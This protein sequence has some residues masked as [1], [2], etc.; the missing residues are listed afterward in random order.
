MTQTPLQEIL[1][2]YRSTVTYNDFITV[3]NIPLEAYD[4]V[5]NGTNA[6]EWVKIVNHLPTLEIE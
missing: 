6:I 4:Y 3:K 1:S 2:A 5:V